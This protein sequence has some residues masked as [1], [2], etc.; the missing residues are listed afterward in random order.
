MIDYP[1]TAWVYNC[2][3]DMR[4]SIDGL[5][6]LV[7]N[8]ISGEEGLGTVFV[9]INKGGDKIKILL[10]QSNG[11]CLLYKRLDTKRFLLNVGKAGSA[12][13]DDANVSGGINLSRQQ[14]R[15]LLQGLDWQKLSNSNGCEKSSNYSV[16]C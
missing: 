11:F 7:A 10:K 15:W 2:A 4:R 3:V 12:V 13:G 6:M 16:F 1:N 9:F 14:L 8:Q 5:S